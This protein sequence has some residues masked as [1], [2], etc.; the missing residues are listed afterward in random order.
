MF[1]RNARNHLEMIKETHE[2]KQDDTHADQRGTFFKIGQSVWTKTYSDKVKWI[3]GTI[4]GRSGKFI[5][6]VDTAKG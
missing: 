3:K 5:Y 4:V 2:S 6:T 1:G